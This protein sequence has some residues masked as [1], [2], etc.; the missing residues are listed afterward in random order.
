MAS[1]PL[2][3]ALLYAHTG[4]AGGAPSQPRAPGDLLLVA[5]VGGTSSTISIVQ[6]CVAS[7]AEG[8]EG[9]GESLSVVA[10]ETD[11]SLG[12]AAVDIGVRA[13]VLK[14]L[15]RRQRVD[16]SDH[17]RAMARLL[18]ECEG[19]KRTLTA[20]AQASIAVEA[21]G[22]D[23]TCSLS[24]RAVDEAA[25]PLCASLAK[26]ARRALGSAGARPDDVTALLLVGGGARV[27]AV[28]A[29]LGG[30]VP[31]APVHFGAISDEVVCRGAALLADKPHLA[32]TWRAAEIRRAPLLPRALALVAA[33]GAR[34]VIAHARA[35]LPLRRVAR[36]RVDGADDLPVR[37]H[38][39]EIST[40]SSAEIAPAEAEEERT[41]GRLC[42]RE[43]PA[44]ESSADLEIVLEV[45]AAGAVELACEA[46][47]DAD[48]D[49]DADAPQTRVRLARVAAGAP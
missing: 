48:A 6:R 5:D 44:G 41:V 4:A 15:R 14:E 47:V 20:S 38:L 40:A 16:L 2:L 43:L 28:Q 46:L 12:G 10:A 19:A 9:E 1:E 26:L 45:D 22:A 34:R 21:D 17:A 39:V 32:S 13:H 24:R 11:V 23:Y 42:V 3:A 35:P 8:A 36:A 25:A 30:V 18:A 29:A 49:A 33:D 7:S 37:V 31:S 27:P